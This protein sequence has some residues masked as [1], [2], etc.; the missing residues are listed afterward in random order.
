MAVPT[1]V[2]FDDDTDARLVNLSQECGLSKADLIRR[3]TVEYLERALR[4]GEI[5]IR[6]RETPVSYK[7]KRKAQ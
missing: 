5:N 4:E 3:A 6:L 7:T 1:S 2:R